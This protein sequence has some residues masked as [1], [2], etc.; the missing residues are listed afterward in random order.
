MAKKKKDTRIKAE[1]PRSVAHERADSREPSG[2]S[3]PPGASTQPSGAENQWLARYGLAIVATTALIVRLVHWWYVRTNDPLYAHTLPETDMHTYWEWA[4]AIAGGDWLS[5]KQ[6]IFYYGP[7][8]PYFLAPLF[9]A[10]GPNYD[11]VHGVQVLVGVIAPI[12]VYAT[13][14][15][16]ADERAGF[17]AGLLVALCGP[18]LFY[19]QL[20]LM[21]GL[22]VAIHALFLWSVARGL[23]S[24]GRSAARFAAL[25]GVLAGLACLGRGNFQLVGALFVPVWWLA[26][27]LSDAA[28]STRAASASMPTAPSCAWRNTLAYAIAFGA[29]I[30]ASLA[31]NRIVGGQWVL[32]TSNGPILLY[33]GNAPDSMGIFHYPD[34]F[35]ALKEKYGGDQGAVPWSQELLRSILQNPLTFFWGLLRKLWIFLNAYDVADNSNIYLLGRFSPLVKWN[36][37]GWRLIVSLGFVGAWLTRRNW[38]KHFFLYAYALAFCASIVAV[39]VVGRYRL[40]FLLPFA[41]WAGIA[42]GQAIEWWRAREWSAVAAAA[43]AA[44]CLMLVLSPQLSPAAKLNTPPGVPGTRLIRPNDFLLLARAY[45]ETNHP[46]EA[47]AA[48]REGF[49]IHPWDRPLALHLANMLEQSK[50]RDAAIRVLKRYLSL[51]RGDGDAALALAQL[52]ARNGETAEALSLVQQILRVQ[53]DNAGAQAL[54]QRLI[55]V[56]GANNSLR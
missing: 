47:L 22:L 28:R 23:A 20:L 26:T 39:F 12:A 48:L 56:G 15:I 52:L 29:V 41:L 13:G 36:P 33:I 27:R 7:L 25:S 18:I 32:S 53:P 54:L 5:R 14:R 43:G 21:E 16:I 10:F 45:K 30:V 31:R 55:Q 17:I 38:R 49:E 9:V 44:L 4:K 19:E 24:E 34:S 37:I 50:D 35:L 1:Q 51:M 6:G 11:I 8:Y 3:A 46:A 2:M 40:E 42:V